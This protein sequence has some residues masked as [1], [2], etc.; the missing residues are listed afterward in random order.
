MNQLLFN[1]IS[2]ISNLVSVTARQ[3]KWFK[4]CRADQS[5]VNFPC[6]RKLEIQCTSE[7]KKI[8]KKLEEN[9]N[10]CSV[11]CT[12]NEAVKII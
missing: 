3:F 12:Y 1:R 6:E 9:L 5:M 7:A 11:H 4:K 10:N 8:P 2:M